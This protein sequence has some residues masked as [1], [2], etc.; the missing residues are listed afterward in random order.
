MKRAGR[1]HAQ[2]WGAIHDN[3]RV[4]LQI[5]ACGLSDRPWCSAHTVT[6]APNLPTIRSLC[7]DSDN[8]SKV[9]IWF[10]EPVYVISPLN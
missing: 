8:K 6:L 1:A 7:C 2:I 5:A 9:T 10:R 3:R 4:P